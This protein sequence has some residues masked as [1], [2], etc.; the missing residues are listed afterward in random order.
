MCS[1]L[2]ET[3]EVPFLNNSA[4]I[5]IDLMPEH[6]V[7]VGG[8]DVGNRGPPANIDIDLVG[9]QNFIVDHEGV[10]R[11]KPGMPSDDRA[12]ARSS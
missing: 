1:T 10:C 6:L 7:I 8:A 11:L 2:L 3:H 5:G 9:L 12:I 4:M